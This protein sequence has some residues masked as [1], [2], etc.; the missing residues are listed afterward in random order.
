MWYTVY[1]KIARWCGWDG[2]KGT[3]IPDG[4]VLV[5]DSNEQHGLFEIGTHDGLVVAQKALSKPQWREAGAEGDYTVQGYESKIGIERKVAS[6]LVSYIGRERKK[7]DAKLARLAHMAANG[8]FAAL[9]V[10]LD[11]SRLEKQLRYTQITPEHVRGFLV[12]C[13]LMGIHVYCS[14]DRGRLRRFV[15]DHTTKAFKVLKAME[16]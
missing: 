4:F 14:K 5:Q 11:E 12:K 10:G 6:D 2:L 8:G 1:R 15:L 13:R 9:I 3:I 7:T 16:G